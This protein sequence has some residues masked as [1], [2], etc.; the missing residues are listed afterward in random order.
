ME[1]GQKAKNWQ[2][3]IVIY[4]SH[5]L[6]LFLDTHEFRS[7]SNHPDDDHDDDDASMSKRKVAYYY[8]SKLLTCSSSSQLT[9]NW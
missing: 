9:T 6:S 8:D 3:N 4:Q 7:W 2:G 5:D 1:K